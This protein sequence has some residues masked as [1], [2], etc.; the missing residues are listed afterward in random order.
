MK[1]SFQAQF[2]LFVAL[3][4]TCGAPLSAQRDSLMPEPASVTQSEGRLGI[5]GE[6]RVA[7]TGYREPR[8]EEATWRLI[9]RLTQRTGIPYLPRLSPD[10]KNATLLISCERAGETVQSFRED[11]SYKLEVKSQQARLAAATPLGVLRGMETFL[12]LV[13]LDSQGFHL[14]AVRIDD[15]PRFLWRGLMIEVTCHFMPKAVILRNL[16]AMAAVKLNV[17]HLHLTDDQGFR[18]ESRRFPKL[19]A[20]GSDGQYYSQE[21]I[22]EIVAF[23]RDRGIR[24]VPEFDMPGHTAS[25]L[26]GY[27][28]LASAPG[29][30]A[31]VRKFGI[32]DPTMDPTREDL[33][34][35]LDGFIGE[36]AGLFPDEYFHIGGDEVNGKQW[37]ANPQ[38]QAFM[39]KNELKSNRDLQSHFNRRLL[40]ILQK[41]GKKMLGWEEVLHPDTP[42]DIIVH[43]WRGQES[44]AGAIRQGNPAILS[45]GYY[46]DYIQSAATH[47]AVDPMEGET[48]GLSDKERALIL[49]GEACMWGEYV[50]SEN[51]DSRIWPRLAAI[52][53]RLWSPQSVKDVDSMYHRAKVASSQAEWLG[54]EHRRNPRL[55]LE[56]LAGVDA[57]PALE[58]LADIMEPTPFGRRKDP[59]AYTS[60][61]PLNR[62]VDATQPESLAAR[63]FGKLVENIRTNRVEIRRQL[64]MWSIA[65][66]EILPVMK[67]SALLLEAIPLAEDIG[68]LAA[69]GMVAL[70]YLEAGRRAPEAWL[71]RQ[72]S[73]LGR[74]EETRADL[75]IAIVP[76]VRKL[77]EAA[78]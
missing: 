77:V 65:S 72:V 16:D 56:R 58:A 38:I 66:R 12:Q 45:S 26:V 36:M 14:P 75:R 43:S 71:K 49:G 5:D 17:L 7:L 10:D 30:Y 69:A 40:P 46:L 57:A 48:A 39:R 37:D 18:V 29:P 44:L 19:H 3:L 68:A 41:H 52:A 33:Y 47:Y 8:L 32:F 51:I 20:L 76:A 42:R 28:E 73:L 62:L 4:L 1:R 25:W 22:R 23:A 6:F 55:M 27:P 54:A 67:R 50:S 53:E 61:T 11:E 13:T 74:A 78:R 31:I 2:I 24:V 9:R 15:R 70:D 59:R 64:R 34:A 63:D 60:Y 35:F 21:E